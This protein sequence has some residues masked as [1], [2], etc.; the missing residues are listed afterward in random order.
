MT[1]CTVMGGVG[2]CGS[3]YCHCPIQPFVL[4]CSHAPLHILSQRSV[5]RNKKISFLLLLLPDW[6]LVETHSRCLSDVGTERDDRKALCATGREN[7]AYYVGSFLIR[8]FE[9]VVQPSLDQP[10]KMR[11]TKIFSQVPQAILL[12]N[13]YALPGPFHDHLH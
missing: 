1:H 11:G 3:A 6:E 10:Q 12:K 7:I 4:F 5:E 9:V 13:S 8:T 2:S